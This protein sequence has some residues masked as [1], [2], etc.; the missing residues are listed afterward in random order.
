MDAHNSKQTQLICDRAED[1]EVVLRPQN[2]WLISSDQGPPYKTQFRIEILASNK[3][4]PLRRMGLIGS[5]LEFRLKTD[6]RSL[7][8][9]SKLVEAVDAQ[10]PLH[11]EIQ[12]EFNSKRPGCFVQDIILDSGSPPYVHQSVTVAV[13]PESQHGQLKKLY[14]SFRSLVTNAV[15]TVATVFSD[16]ASLMSAACK[17]LL[18]PPSNLD[19]YKQHLH[20]VL[21]I[22]EIFSHN[23]FRLGTKTTQKIKTTSQTKKDENDHL[24]THSVI[25]KLSADTVQNQCLLYGD[26]PRL[27][28]GPT[29][30]EPLASRLLLI[31]PNL[32]I[33]QKSAVSNILGPRSY[34][35][36]LIDGPPGAGKTRV[37]FEAARSLLQSEKAKILMCTKTTKSAEQFIRLLH[38]FQ[39][40][41]LEKLVYMNN[42]LP[43]KVVGDNIKRYQ[44]SCESAAKITSGIVLEHDSVLVVATLSDC[45]RFLTPGLVHFTHVLIDEASRVM[46]VHT[47]MAL[48]LAT[49]EAVVVLAGDRNEL[50]PFCHWQLSDG[51]SLFSRLSKSNVQCNKI[52]L[53]SQFQRHPVLTQLVSCMLNSTS[54]KIT[55]LNDHTDTAFHPFSVFACCGGKA[56]QSEA[57]GSFCNLMEA[58]TVVTQVITLIQNWPEDLGNFDASQIFVVSCEQQQLKAIGALLRSQPASDG[59][60]CLSDVGIGTPWEL[61]GLSPQVVIIS[62]VMTEETDQDVYKR[63]R[64]FLSDAEML[65]SAISEAKC[66]VEVVGDPFCLISRGAEAVQSMWRV[67]LQHC[68]DTGRS[69]LRGDLHAKD[70]AVR[71]RLQSVKLSIG[72]P[73]FIPSF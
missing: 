27:R 37:L 33:E 6:C 1:M 28:T 31:D 32:T 56:D 30:S 20:T 61:Q 2:V 7:R 46:E 14:H 3:E 57:D 65:Y 72:S 66:M 35:C 9:S 54:T 11:V 36:L 22:E 17:T 58:E 40:P 49:P 41:N 10:P 12:V 55:S 39:T 44:H 51:Q 13:V 67:Y 21:Y 73:E 48:T 60:A 50:Q 8:S 52:S 26:I 34:C 62:T 63:K 70:L 25:D 45:C 18:H 69:A 23:Q 19:E 59:L 16:S 53:T 47:V 29:I 24:A 71:I 68:C 43:D 4:R 64:C 38:Q 15:R 42:A 5:G